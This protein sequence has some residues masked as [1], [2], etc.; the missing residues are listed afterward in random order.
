VEET[1][2]K[3][4][5][6]RSLSVLALSMAVLLTGHPGAVAETP[7][8]EQ[9]IATRHAAHAKIMSGALYEGVVDLW[10]AFHALPADD[11]KV[12]DDAYSLLQLLVFAVEYL[13]TPEQAQQFAGAFL[14]VESNDR[15]RL[16]FNIL[17]VTF[18]A[19][20]ETK[21]AM[22]SSLQA[23]GGSPDQVVQPIARFFM[24]DPYFW[25]PPCAPISETQSMALVFNYPGLVLTRE[26]IRMDAYNFRRSDP[27]DFRR[28]LEHMHGREH[29]REVV[30]ADPLLSGVMALS[31]LLEGDQAARSTALGHVAQKALEHADWDVRD[32]ALLLLAPHRNTGHEALVEAVV[33]DLAQRRPITPDVARAQLIACRYARLHGRFDEALGWLDVL[34]SQERDQESYE[35][36]LYEAVMKE[37]ERSAR[38]FADN[39]ALV[40]ASETYQRLIQRYPGSTVAARS[41]EALAALDTQLARR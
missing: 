9:I 30:E 5:S 23:L 11:A 28:N 24:S 26:A 15:D 19:D 32:G 37:V 33:L 21:T 20:V 36:N 39:G 14:Q 25:G 35:R 4:H 13:M 38:Y 8:R 10:K 22:G 40:E 2:V 12:A 18:G 1:D 27:G 3:N 16:I 17:N 31:P 29:V 7:L 6:C 41:A 34:L